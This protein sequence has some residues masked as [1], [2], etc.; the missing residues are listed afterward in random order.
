[1]KFA[2]KLLL[3]LAGAMILSAQGAGH[4]PVR[5]LTSREGLLSTAINAIHQDADG[6]L[7]VGTEIGLERFDGRDLQP[8]DVPL[9]DPIVLSLASAGR[10]LWV[11]TLRGLVVLENGAP[12]PAPQGFP[13]EIRTVTHLQRDPDGP[14][15]FLADGLPWRGDAGA[16]DLVGAL[17]GT[18]RASALFV[19]P[20]GGPALVCGANRLFRF[21]GGA[22]L[23]LEG[24]RLAPR[25]DLQAVV[26]DGAGRI[27]LRTTL[28]CW[29]QAASGAWGF[30]PL[31]TAGGYPAVQGLGRCPDGSIW[32]AAGAHLYRAQGDR[33]EQ[34]A[35]PQF[36]PVVTACLD[37]EG[38]L[39]IG[40]SKLFQ[41]M[42]RGRWRYWDYSDG[43]PSRL[44]WQVLHDLQGR[45]WAAT[46]AGLALATP[47]GWRTL[48][49]GR[50]SRMALAPDGT[51]WTARSDAVAVYRIR[52]GAAR[53]EPVAAPGDFPEGAHL[54]SLATQGKDLW[55]VAGDHLWRGRT[56]A[57]GVAWATQPHPALGRLRM[58]ADDGHGELFLT[59]DQ[60]L[61]FRRGEDWVK[62]QGLGE[63]SVRALAWS[64]AGEVALGYGSSALI[65]ILRRDAGGW[66][67][68]RT[69]D[70]LPKGLKRVT[71]ALAY[72]RRDRLWIG[73]NRGLFRLDPRSDVELVGYEDGEGMVGGDVSHQSL[74][75]D[76]A[77]R[78]WVCT[79]A[80]INRFEPESG[81]P[82]IGLPSPVILATTIGSRTLAA[83]A[84]LELAVGDRLQVAFA[85]P[86]YLHPESM[87]YQAILDDGRR[88]TVLALDRPHL[89]LPDLGAHT[90]RVTL[91]GL[92]PDQGGYGPG[93]TFQVAARPPFWARGWAY[94]VLAALAAVLG[95]GLHFTRQAQLRRRAEGLEALVGQ[96]TEEL[97]Q[98]SLAKTAFLA[99]M[100]HELRTPLNAILLYSEL[101]QEEA[102]DA[103]RP[104]EGADAARIHGAG[105]HLLGLIDN[106]LDLA[107]IE[108]G[109]MDLELRKLELAPFLVDLEWALRPLI[110]ARDN[111]FRI[112]LAPDLA[113]L[114][115]DL[116]RLRQILS[117]LLSNAGKFTEHGQVDLEAS[118]DG[119]Y[120]VF[121]VRDTGIGMDP[122][123]L[124]RVFDP[125][126]QADASTT[127]R[128]GGTGLGLSLV[129]QLTQV[130]GGTVEAVSSPGAGSLF[131]VRLP[132]EPAAPI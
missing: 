53:P 67:L 124:K 2:L 34:L 108:A 45:L 14:M 70:L 29:S 65:K 27:W 84:P 100:S 22:W 107:K 36:G 11:G 38:S 35:N 37:R 115:T 94:L 91:R 46:D 41:V 119:A 74:H 5:V 106:I 23:P 111:R 129:H 10:Q 56:S 121:R 113:D 96:R 1:M 98:A 101:L 13:T 117:N 82:A 102:Q 63:H 105:H 130:L 49:A 81:A 103:G 30:Q 114:T 86:T 75:F 132:L 6:L 59:G 95:T 120:A 24:P 87:H 57:G 97:R 15:W 50:F 42:G 126:V 19:D 43:L 12:L 55:I 104:A 44:S 64:G 33:W 88:S 40:A 112:T 80:A 16:V 78:L 52:P 83:G 58:L 131:T 72:D 77:G 123:Q 54:E 17:P 47:A 8:I 110:E 9:P 62:V 26:R 69:L 4:V 76:L 127:R 90:Y 18:F 51:L 73:T 3:A 79:E 25:E 31:E 60:G 85:V 61:M 48:L 89:D 71:Y 66:V 93:T 128:F 125:F 21:Q 118:R 99:N 20:A 68:D 116:V 28:G 109:R 32:I 7:W 39:W 92:L 122:E